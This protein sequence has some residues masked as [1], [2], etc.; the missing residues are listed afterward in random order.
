MAVVMAGLFLGSYSG[1]ETPKNLKKNGKKLRSV[2]TGL[3]LCIF[4]AFWKLV[5]HQPIWKICERQIGSFSPQIGIKIKTI[6]NHQ[7]GLLC[8]VVPLDFFARPIKTRLDKQRCRGMNLA[9]GT[10]WWLISPTI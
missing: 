8:A 9:A 3:K 5:F 1:S 4:F 6:W 10:R 2:S 7:L